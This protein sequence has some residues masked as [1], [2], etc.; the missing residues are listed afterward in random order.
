MCLLAFWMFLDYYGG[1]RQE[2]AKTGDASEIYSQPEETAAPTTSLAPSAKNMAT[3]LSFEESSSDEESITLGFAGDIN[4]DESWM[5]MKH[6]R[7]KGKGISGCIDPALI[8]KMRGYDAMILNNEFAFSNRGTPMSGKAYTFCAPTKNVNILKQLGVD[9]VSLANN[10]VYDYGKSAFLDTLTTLKKSGIQYTG[11]G[12]NKKEAIKPAYI[13]CKGRKIAIIAATRAEKYILTPAAGKSSPGVFRTYDDTEYVKAIRK[14]SRKADY[15]IAFV[16]WG[17][18]YSTTLE[19]AQKQQAKDYI[20]AGADMVVG[21]H[22]HCLQG[23]GYYK[24]KPIFYSLGNFWFNEKTLYTTLLQ[25]QITSDGRLSAKM[26]PCL[27]S[28]KETKLLTSK[29][30]VRKFIKYVNNVSTNARLN[31]KCVVGK[32]DTK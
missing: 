16:H 19:T 4:L 9:V 22:T 20:N 6:M 28:G 30:K 5:V 26:L 17:T 10:H 23:A 21:A 25:V 13:Q 3:T 11:G 8:Q 18:E 27:Q 7:K 24:G 1:T 32:I 31:A 29:K 12:K 14:A 2:T 15:V